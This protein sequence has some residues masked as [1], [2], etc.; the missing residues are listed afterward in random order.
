MEREIELLDRVAPAEAAFPGKDEAMADVL[1]PRME[2][3]ARNVR[4]LLESDG[5]RERAGMRGLRDR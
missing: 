4:S 1:R 2:R 3:T 5:Y